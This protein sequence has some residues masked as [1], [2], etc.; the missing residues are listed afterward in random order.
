MLECASGGD[1]I[2]H[3]VDDGRF[4]EKIARHIFKEIIAGTEHCHENG[5]IHRD[6]KPDNLLF[7][8]NFV[9]KIADFGLSSLGQHHAKYQVMSTR[10]GTR[11]FQAPEIVQG[12]K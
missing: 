12:R 9:I 5:I 4:E 8:K 1:L 3:I 7:T 6:M 2:K 11:G 10:V